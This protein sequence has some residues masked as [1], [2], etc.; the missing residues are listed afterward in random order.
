MS[1]A[2]VL[3]EAAIAAICARH[4]PVPGHRPLLRALKSALAVPQLRLALVDDWFGQGGLIDGEGTRVTD[5]L[6]GW[7]LEESG[8]DPIE[9]FSRHNRSPYYVTR[10]VGRTLYTIV[11][12]GPAPLDFVQIEIDM[13]AEAV[14]RALFDGSELPETLDE[15]IG[16]Q[17]GPGC[18]GFP[19][20]RPAYTLRRVTDFAQRLGDLTDEHK[21]DPRF[22][23]FLSEWSESSAG[24]SM[25]LC[26]HWVLSVVPYTSPEGEHLVEARPLPTRSV[27]LPDLQCERHKPDY[28]PSRLVQEVDRA[29]GYPMAWYFIQV[30]RHYATFRCMNAVLEDLLGNYAEIPLAA[31][32]LRLVEDWVDDPYNFY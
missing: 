23:R 10:V 29:A 13:A 9:L 14:E 3:D 6:D 26:D 15:L 20:A 2:P 5:D 28:H 25:R 31:A 18:S 17:A 32:D 1:I 16:P 22:R 7:A 24:Q 8:G 30:A 27:K 11:P 4:V 12:T 21:G 19:L